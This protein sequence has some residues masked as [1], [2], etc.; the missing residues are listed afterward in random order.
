MPVSTFQT[1]P[2][3]TARLVS[4]IERDIRCG[5]LTPGMRMMPRN[6]LC[7]RFEVSSGVVNNA[8]NELERKGLI[9]RAARSGVIVAPKVRPA[10]SLLLGVVTSYD[11]GNIE[12]Y[13]EPLLGAA[14]EQRMTPM[15]INLHRD[16]WRQTLG[17]LASRAPDVVAVDVE[18]R[19]FPLEE[20]EG[21]LLL[22]PICYVNRFEWMPHRRERAVLVDYDS[23]WGEGLKTLWRRGHDRILQVVYGRQP[24]P[25]MLRTL[26]AGRRLAGFAPDDDRLATIAIQD[27]R[28]TPESVRRHVAEFAPTAVLSQSD[29][30]MELVENLCP[31]TVDLE[32]IGFFDT[33]HSR[34]PGHEFSSFHI[35][36]ADV[37]RRVADAFAGEPRVVKLPPKLV[38]RWPAGRCPVEGGGTP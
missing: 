3:K 30:Y 15:I 37:W 33:L 6:E 24:E 35:D 28:E 36:F 32:R 12:G 16:G 31:E 9:M 18:A 23:A 27:L 13:F 20:L 5:V 25:H 34:R 2:T 29:Y 22:A 8:Y 10:D 38:A 26:A 1:P 21:M 19:F 11:R 17:D 4:K 7:T 14:R